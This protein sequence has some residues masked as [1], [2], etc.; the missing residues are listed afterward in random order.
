MPV[1]GSI[2]PIGILAG[3]KVVGAPGHQIG[4][5]QSAIG[6]GISGLIHPIRRNAVLIDIV[7]LILHGAGIIDRALRPRTGDRK[8]YR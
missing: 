1:V 3:P 5:E 4:G 2:P 6:H 8:K 7:A